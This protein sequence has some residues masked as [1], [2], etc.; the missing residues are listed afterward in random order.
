[1]GNIFTGFNRETF[2]TKHE[3]AGI[4]APGSYVYDSIYQRTFTGFNLFFFNLSVITALVFLG[5]A[6]IDPQFNS[7]TSFNWLIGVNIA[8]LV[9]SLLGAARFYTKY[10]N[11]YTPI[12]LGSEL[13]ENAGDTN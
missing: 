10:Q 11:E 1:M 9:I 3:R 6:L 13:T 4:L 2:F 12:S 5:M 8:W 7:D